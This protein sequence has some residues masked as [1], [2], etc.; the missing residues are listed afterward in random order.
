MGEKEKKLEK[1]GGSLK[2]SI[3]KLKRLKTDILVETSIKRLGPMLAQYEKEN[4]Y[5]NELQKSLVEIDEESPLLDKIKA[6]NRE[7]INSHQPE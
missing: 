1:L 6:I 5:Y 4:L 2:A 7:F 3:D